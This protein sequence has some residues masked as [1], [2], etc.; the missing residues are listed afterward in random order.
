MDKPLSS[1][2]L[3]AVP[4]RP[5]ARPSRA[6]ALALC[7]LALCTSC[8]DLTAIAKF[9]TSA[10]TATT[11]F[12][13]IADDFAASAT[14]RAN[15]VSAAEKPK[16]IA[17]AAAYKAEQPQTDAAQKVLADY[18]A[19]LTAI[20][21]DATTTAREANINA[22]P[23][24]A[25]LQKIGMTS[26]QATAT[27]GLAAKLASGLTAAYRSDKAGHAI[28]DSNADLQAFL[29]G[30]EQI[31]G[32]D[33]THVLNSEHDSVQAYYDDL[34]HNYGATEPL[35]KVVLLKQ[36]QADFAAIT[37]KQ[38]AATAYV[39]LLTDLGAAHQKLYDA[40]THMSNKELAG[41]LEP[42]AEDIATQSAKV[43]TAF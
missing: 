33:Y 31:A 30:L 28:H 1:R 17:E 6:A 15:Y 13:A 40:G 18:I 41:I 7:L 12:A 11:G 24:A 29:Q 36:E 34:I 19:A 43:A 20:S 38:Q 23:N 8:A 9:A 2:A 14:R 42:Y 3:A 5:L 37:T 26:A 27:L 32:T 16:V 10:K 4:P 25:D 35:A 39:K 21:T 22:T